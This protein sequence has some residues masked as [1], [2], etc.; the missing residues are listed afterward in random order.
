MREFWETNRFV[1]LAIFVVTV[2][3]I[4]LISSAGSSTTL[5]PVLPNQLAQIRVTAS[6]AFSYQ[7]RLKTEL[8]REQILNRVPPV[9]QIELTPYQ[10]F[11]THVRELLADLSAYE[12]SL[13]KPA[14]DGAAHPAPS[15]AAPFRPRIAPAPFLP[16]EIS[17]P[18]TP[19]APLALISIKD[20]FNAN[21][22]YRLTAEDIAAL[23]TVGNSQARSALVENG[24][25]NLR[26]IYNEGVH[27][28]FGG[29]STPD[30]VSL[31]QLRNPNGDVH[32]SRVMS[33]ED[34][35]TYLRVN[36][37]TEGLSRPANR[38]VF[39]LFRNG[40]TPNLVYDREATSRLQQQAVAGLKTSLVTVERGQ[41]IISPGD[42]VTPEQY[43]MLEAYRHFLE[44]SG[45]AALDQ[46]LQLFG[47]VLLVLAMVMASVFYIRLEDPETLQRN[48]RLG[49]LALVVIFNLA[50]VRGSYSLASLPY[51]VDNFSAAAL[52]PYI[53]PT[54]LAPLI[55]TILIDTGSATFMA[56]LISI[57]TGVIYGNRLD[58]VVLTLLASMVG[59]F[60]CRNVRKRGR[61]V[62]AAG[63]G[64]LTVACFALLIGISDQTP[65]GTVLRQMGA[66][67]ATGLFTGVLVAGL[68]PVLESL[69]KRTTDITLLE[70]TDF[71]HPLLR[72]MQMEAPGTYHHS[73]MVAQLAE[74]AA[75]AVG[76]NPLLA[77]V[78]SLFHD[79]GK[80]ARPE[81]FTEN[82]RE[83]ANPHDKHA[84]AH[85]ALVIKSHVRDGVDLAV[86]HR[87]PRAV[88]DAIQQHHG[89]TLIQ[90]FYQRAKNERPPL[91][92][93]DPAGVAESA[94]RYDGPKPQFREAAIIMLADAV[95][96]AS[97]SLRKVT[98]P[99]L[100]EIIDRITAERIANGQLD[101]AP[102]TFE[103]IGKIKTSFTFTLLNMLHSRIAYPPAEELPAAKEDQNIK[104]R[105]R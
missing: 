24:L 40:L 58:L 17:P 65:P 36:L 13:L 88:V 53:A 29:G 22:P 30:S 104:S 82:Q 94:Y 95:E 96:A 102:L 27:D 32:E 39:N 93:T 89:T 92:A 83:R 71:N 87:L 41:T 77:R 81:Y 50:L 38:A 37:S 55:V 67:I 74:N 4:V 98:P 56:L 66:G 26:E 47:R 48:G 84:P 8:T 45:S 42:R 19:E 85:S 2:A 52:L 23:L 33:L 9:Y 79:I 20:R 63:F 12:Q 75:N 70:L 73:L 46:G 60:Y 103:D 15:P 61:I 99:A 7:S 25:A 10:Q 14:P 100:G 1:S 59:L 31:F 44:S 97:R 62:K 51:F 3:A 91:P 86:K 101:D 28:G 18:S 69:F 72:L 5:L 49:L 78:C 57:F 54:A 68:L 16:P 34:A 11:E 43:E 105:T 35:L 21:G 6:A 64:G 80:T 90:Y 76:A